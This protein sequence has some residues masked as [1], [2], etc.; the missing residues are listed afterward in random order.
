MKYS[1]FDNSKCVEIDDEI[2]QMHEMYVHSV[3]SVVLEGIAV[4]CGAENKN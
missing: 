1:L 4:A 3:D 2:I